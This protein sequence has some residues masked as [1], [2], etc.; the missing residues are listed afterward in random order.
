MSLPK[1]LIILSSIL[2]VLTLGALGYIGYSFAVHWHNSVVSD[3]QLRGRAEMFNM[4]YDYAD[5]NGVVVLTSTGT[6]RQAKLRLVL[7]PE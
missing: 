3:A 2:A 7:D 5:A 1:K 4:I 6:D